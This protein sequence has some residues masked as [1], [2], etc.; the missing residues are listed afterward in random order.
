MDE[1]AAELAASGEPV[2]PQ[3]LADCDPGDE[4]AEVSEPPLAA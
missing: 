3:Y 1:P 2:E 4:T